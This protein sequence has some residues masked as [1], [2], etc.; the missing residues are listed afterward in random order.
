MGRNSRK[1]S[2]SIYSRLS[3]RYAAP[4]SGATSEGRD[5]GSIQFGSAPVAPEVADRTVIIAHQPSE[6]DLACFRKLV[7]GTFVKTVIIAH[8]VAPL[9]AI[10]KQD[11]I[12]A[13]TPVSEALDADYCSSLFES[14]TKGD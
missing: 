3:G 7:E 12:A 8:P 10:Y 6:D 1:Y 4:M 11:V 14:W 9:T 13:A 2:P 5:V